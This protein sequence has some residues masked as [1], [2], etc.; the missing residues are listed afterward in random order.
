MCRGLSTGINYT[1]VMIDVCVTDNILINEML[2][3]AYIGKDLLIMS[4]LRNCFVTV[5]LPVTC[6]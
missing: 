2:Q 1:N 6:C 3:K 4:M 5:F